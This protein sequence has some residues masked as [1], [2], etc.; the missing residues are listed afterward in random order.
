[1]GGQGGARGPKGNRERNR[2]GDER[3]WEKEVEEV[4][5]MRRV[6][7]RLKMGMRRQKRMK[8]N[9]EISS[10]KGPRTHKKESV[11]NMHVEQMK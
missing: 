4:R 9:R 7:M 10:S 5:G 11:R 1:M 8:R 3:R 6:K 2:K